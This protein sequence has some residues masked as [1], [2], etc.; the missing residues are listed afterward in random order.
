MSD[1][2]LGVTDVDTYYGHIHAL[3]NISLKVKRG[4]YQNN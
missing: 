4:D 1:L 3:K 2:F